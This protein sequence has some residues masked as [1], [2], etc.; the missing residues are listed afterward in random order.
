MAGP[1]QL[2]DQREDRRFPERIE[3]GYTGIT[4]DSRKVLP[5]SIFVAIPGAKYDGTDFIPQ[6][7]EAGAKMIV[8][9]KPV[10]VP[11][12]VK[13]KKVSSARRALAQ[14]ACKFY[15]DPSKKLKIIEITKMLSTLNDSSMR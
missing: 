15:G 13:F 11:A 10:E 2:A 12:G 8:A 1:A 7:I 3:V 6:A 4:Y 5:G 14:M 9:E